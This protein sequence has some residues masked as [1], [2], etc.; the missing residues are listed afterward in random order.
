MSSAAGAEMVSIVRLIKRRREEEK[1]D[2]GEVR[3]VFMLV[4]PSM[5]CGTRGLVGRVN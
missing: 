4:L 2:G 1:V 5:R 3:G